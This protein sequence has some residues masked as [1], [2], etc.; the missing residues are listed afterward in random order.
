MKGN[1]CFDV[2]CIIT[3]HNEGYLAHRTITSV[4]LCRSYAEARGLKTELVLVLDCPDA[5]TESVVRDHFA[6]REDDQI[7]TV[8]NRSLPLSRND[9]VRASRGA[10]LS[11]HDGD[12][13]YSENLVYEGVSYCRDHPDAV[14]HVGTLIE[15]EANYCFNNLYRS[16]Y[17]RYDFVKQHPLISQSI[18]RRETYEQTPYEP[19]G[20][21][22]G[23]EDWHWNAETLAKGLVHRPLP[24]T[25]LFYRR[26]RSGSMLSQQAGAKSL[27]RP[28]ALFDQLEAVPP[29][30]A[31]PKA[32]AAP[33]DAEPEQP[34]A[35][36]PPAPR[37]PSLAY[38]CLK[39]SA[40]K[41]ISA[42]PE[43]LQLPAKNLAWS[44]LTLARLTRDHWRR[45]SAPPAEPVSP[46]PLG[47]SAQEK[48]GEI[49][50][51]DCLE[52]LKKMALLD[53][54]LHPETNP[55]LYEYRYQPDER[56]GRLFARLYSPLKEKRY[57]VVYVAP[58]LVRG[59]ADLMAI[60]FA[61]TLAQEGKAVLVI[62]TLAG[63]SPWRSRLDCRVDFADL[64]NAADGFENEDKKLLLARLLL[65]LRPGAVHFMN[66]QLGHETVLDY[67]RALRQCM[68][69]YT[70][71]YCDEK[72]KDGSSTGY[73]GLFLPR[74]LTEVS[75]I[76]T[77]NAVLPEEW[78]KLFG[79]PRELFGVIYG[80][81]EAPADMHATPALGARSVLWAGRFCE[82]KRPDLLLQIADRMPD[83]VF[84][85]YGAPQ[86]DA[87]KALYSQFKKRKNVVLGGVYDGFASLPTEQC[88]CFLYTTCTDGLPNVLLEAAAAGLPIVAP[89]VGGISDFISDQTGWLLS[90]NPSAEDYVK[91]LEE[92]FASAAE[93]QK[94]VS[95]AQ[96]LLRE[97]HSPEAL[98]KSLNDFYWGSASHTE[99]AAR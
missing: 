3:F 74:L 27:I 29:R 72:R 86:N 22:F 46:A 7:L 39:Q 33:C 38:R 99:P 95:S 84:Y 62:T 8:Q 61:N 68:K 49:T 90:P 10:F 36:E 57:D 92:I 78:G 70:T 67:G 44:A 9:A 40:K 80:A 50:M 43:D 23:Y 66:S 88:G 51:K 30:S 17:S 76:S 34:P 26:K 77:D 24:H 15:F 13:Y 6:V 56:L 75:R 85:V 93:C 28:T 4:D 41:A 69:L 32:S 73:V 89:R 60:N 52:A 82:Q 79:A 59:G 5:L 94:R 71:F 97:R 19:T 14:V 54:S 64:G 12:D 91:A 2:S 65:Q 42:L 96:A 83:A 37:K 35:Q 1:T 16:R 98:K 53:T 21:G 45:P 25:F 63:A 20:G 58:W 87:E 31:A 47:P 48:P 18:S 11:I 81:M 55:P